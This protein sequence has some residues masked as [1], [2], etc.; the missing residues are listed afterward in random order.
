MWVGVRF[1]KIFGGSIFKV[2]VGAF[3]KSRFDAF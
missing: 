2:V 1:F 3:S